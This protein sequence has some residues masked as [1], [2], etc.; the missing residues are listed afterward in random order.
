[1]PTWSSRGPAVSTIMHIEI[2]LFAF[3][4]NCFQRLLISP[5]MSNPRLSSVL[6]ISRSCGVDYVLH[7]MDTTVY[8]LFLCPCAAPIWGVGVLFLVTLPIKFWVA[9][10][11]EYS[12]ACEVGIHDIGGLPRCNCN[13]LGAVSH[14]I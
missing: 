5:V 11:V 7:L 2:G 6:E 10:S 8:T 9:C 1:M 3:R 12:F 13:T 4:S 14:M